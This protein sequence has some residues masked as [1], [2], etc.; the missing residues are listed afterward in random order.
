MRLRIAAALALVLIAGAVAVGRWSSGTDPA[1]VAPTWTGKRVVQ[2][3]GPSDAQY[4]T[5]RAMQGAPAPARAGTGLRFEEGR[6]AV[7]WLPPTPY[8][9]GAWRYD[10]ACD[11][12][13]LSMR[14]IV[15]AYWPEQPDYAWAIV[16]CESDLD[17]DGQPDADVVSLRRL[18]GAGEQ[19]AWQIH[20]VNGMVVVPDFEAQTAQ[21]RRIYDA[22]GWQP[23]SCRDARYWR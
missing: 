7:E 8:G 11:P 3:L 15:A 14:E 18:G 6:C 13:P 2:E 16:L 9:D 22:R 5:L 10:L 20:P 23:W 19:G 4:V 1:L 21:A 12:E 17:G